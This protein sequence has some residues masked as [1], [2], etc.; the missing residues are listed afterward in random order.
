MTD[1]ATLAIQFSSRGASQTTSDL[2]RVEAASKRTEDATERL[3]GCVQRL[4]NL[5]AL[6]GIG[7]GVNEI[8]QLADKMQSLR[9]QVQFVT[10]SLEEM[11]RVQGELFDI[12]QRTRASLESTTQL[13]VKSSQALKDYGYAQQDILKFT[14]TIN[15]AMA[16]GGVDA[17]SQASAL[18]QLSQALGSGQLQG[19]EFKTIAESAPIIL[20]V[21][22]EYMGKSRAEVKKL[23]SE[24]KITAQLL[25]EA[26]N[27]SS[28]KIAA[29]FA[30]MPISFGGAVQQMQNALMKFVDDQNQA[31]GITE[32]L[33]EEISFFAR[34][35]DV[36]AVAIGAVVGTR[37]GNF[38]V[39]YVTSTKAAIAATHAQTAA[40]VISIKE[41]IALQ[42]AKV[43]QA[44]ANVVA[45]RTI[46]AETEAKY[47]QLV[48][49]THLMRS[50]QQLLQSELQLARSE[51]TRTAIRDKM[52]TQA[53]LIQQATANEKAVLA[54][55]N[56]QLKQVEISE[57][58][59]AATT[60]GLTAAKNKLTAATVQLSVAQRSAMIVGQGLQSVMAMLGGPLGVVMLAGTALYYFY[61]KSQEAK[62]AALDTTAA[63]DRLKES[64]E[65]LSASILSQKITQQIAGL[66]NY[67]VQIRQLQSDITSL[68]NNWHLVGLDMPDSVKKELAELSDKL[69]VVKENANIDFTVLENQ[70]VALGKT[71]LSAGKT[72]DDVRAKFKLLGVD[73]GNIE[74]VMADLSL[75]MDNNA[76]SAKQA[77]SGYGQF[78][79]AMQKLQMRSMSLEQ[80]MQ[81]LQLRA[82]GNA[83]ASYILAGLYEVLGAEGAEYANVLAAIANGEYASAEA[84]HATV[85]KSLET[86]KTIFAAKDIL[87]GM[88]TNQSQINVY[89]KQIKKSESSGKK[90]S[91]QLKQHQEAWKTHY[92]ELK[93]SSVE[94][95]ERIQLEQDRS[96]KEMLE[97][98]NQAK[99]T[100]SEIEHAKTLILARY[101]K[102]RQKIAEQYA[103]ELKFERELQEQIQE[104]NRLQQAKLLTTEQA[105][106]ALQMLG[107]KYDP[108]L[109]AQQQ[110]IQ[111]L[112]EI[113]LLQ[114]KGSLTDEQAGIAKDK[115]KWEVG[116]QIAKS[117]GEN[118]VSGY[119]RWKA[120]FDPMQA[121]QNDQASKLA[122]LQSYYDQGLIQYQ[123]FVNAKAQ[124][125]AQATADTQNLFMSS[126]SGF[127]TA[128]DTMMGVMK[129]AG[130][131]QSGIYRA[132]FAM[133]KAFAIADSIMKI[134]Q[135]IANAAAQPYP[136]NLAAM[137]TVASQTASIISNIQAVSLGGMA[138]AGIDNIP[139][140]GTWLLDKGE[141]VVDSRTNQDLK[142]F[143]ANANKGGQSGGKST[144]N[145]KIINNGQAVDAKVSQEQRGDET[146]ITVELMKTMQNIA[147]QEANKAITDNFGRAGGTFYR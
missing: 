137:A 103:P 96:I 69:A 125:D 9:N 23:S 65:G 41:E 117:A 55:L 68:K 31:L 90:L 105:G 54:Q 89:E 93:R 121:I 122:E 8:L 140:E 43:T 30:Q 46:V 100:Q 118:A 60:A 138:H 134:Q 35:L 52:R 4:H 145:V 17:Q 24:G 5:L 91:N 48:A 101:T 47:A 112:K 133:S 16:V 76:I 143:L 66:E 110:Y 106:T 3:A 15:K 6:S 61:Q 88:F 135:G 116:N 132:M 81:V 33:A 126:V 58:N 84:A 28:D 102:E 50:Q 2:N 131:E 119:D 32:K 111:N 129:T 38:L 19:D 128:L 95:W 45:T 98:A 34:N 85:G 21:L 108:I 64:Y 7:G 29:R 139:R 27:Q 123:D 49:N 18:L 107:S 40:T 73:S 71:M 51:A 113:E 62:Q 74:W 147:K 44:E 99:A 10:G 104:I 75:A 11:N 20:D 14:E 25:F 70:L 26:F 63:N 36:L 39:S 115:A 87:E 57:K 13:Y 67:G 22:A 42:A 142:T 86:L 78:D 146:H 37:L 80:K 141:R 56:A 72:L 144:V 83:K 92:D 124:I 53:L 82:Q 136:M 12:A 97:K 59:L 109:T 77:A 1:F 79:E 130:K 114:Q 94:G 120:Q 127:G